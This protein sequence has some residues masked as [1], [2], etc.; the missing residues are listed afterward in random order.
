MRR[1]PRPNGTLPY[2]VN[3][4][5]NFAT[6]TVAPQGTRSGIRKRTTSRRGSES[7][8]RRARIWYFG[9]ALGIFYD[10]GYAGVADGAGAWPY[11][12]QNDI[13]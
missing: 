11:A 3:Q 6:M 8:G 12:Q 13:H 5:N 7:P 2:T 1:P 10:L 9:P 4:V